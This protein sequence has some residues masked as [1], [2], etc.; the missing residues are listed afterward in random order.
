MMEPYGFR[1]G[2]TMIGPLTAMTAAHCVTTDS[3]YSSSSSRPNDP[4]RPKT[5]FPIESQLFSLHTYRYN[6]SKTAEE[7]GAII[8]NVTAFEYHPDYDRT[9]NLENDVAV[10]FLSLFNNYGS[11]EAKY[12]A[13]NREPS[14]PVPPEPLRAIGWGVSDI[15]ESWWGGAGYY[16]PDI[17][18][19]VDLPA[20]ASE[21]C[22]DYYNELFNDTWAMDASQLCAGERGKQPCYGDSGSALLRD[23][24]GGEWEQVGIT[25][26]GMLGCKD[27]ASPY[28]FFSR[29]SAVL[30]FVETWLSFQNGSMT[31]TTTPTATT[32][33]SVTRTTMTWV[34]DSDHRVRQGPR[35][36]QQV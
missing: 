6:Q 29:V 10:L 34:G 24:G 11:N 19:Q 9:G 3:Y 7:E 17:L 31:R 2:A 32:T 36:Q 27:P 18:Q 8:Y 28:S 13:L 5:H 30:P 26:F 15:Y 4:K 21:T 20:V 25:S 33:A 14:E 12:V 35:L 23:L 16:Y 22:E 1:C